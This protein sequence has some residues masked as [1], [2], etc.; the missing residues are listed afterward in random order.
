MKNIS[1]V[2]ANN[3]MEASEARV[4]EMLKIKL[5]FIHIDKPKDVTFVNDNI[6]IF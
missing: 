6:L 3:K 4:T 1:Q 5:I 2:F